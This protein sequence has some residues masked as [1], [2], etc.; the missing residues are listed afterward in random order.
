MSEARTTAIQRIIQAAM[1]TGLLTAAQEHELNVRLFQDGCS[2]ADFFLLRR[3][4]ACLRQ[5]SI[6]QVPGLPNPAARGGFGTSL[7]LVT[8]R[9]KKAQPQP[10]RLVGNPRVS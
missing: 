4:H 10:L 3:L 8:D 1:V 5:G 6:R 2:E 9:A 7:R